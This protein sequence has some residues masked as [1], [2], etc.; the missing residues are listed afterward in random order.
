MKIAILGSATS[1]YAKDLQRAAASITA[2]GTR[3]EVTVLPFSR[4]ATTVETTECRVTSVDVQLADFDVTLVRSMP[5]GSLEQVVFRMN[6]L[7]SHE[8]AGY[9]VL[10]SARS[11]E[12]AID[13]Y[14]C[15]TKLRDA[16][17][18]TPA[19]FVCQTVEEAMEG[20]HAFGGDVVVKP[21]F[22]GEGRG[23]ARLNDP[24]IAS[25]A[26][27]L[28]AQNGAVL[29]LQQYIQHDGSDYRLLATGP[30]VFGIERSNKADWR[31][32]MSLGGTASRLDVTPELEE[33]T[34]RAMAATGVQIGALDLLPARDGTVYALEVNAVPGWRATARCLDV[35]VSR[36]VLEFLRDS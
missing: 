6:A 16:G 11:L 10:N 36:S 29:Y 27:K 23:I 9:T 30:R 33:M 31:T 24:A 28:L 3:I 15:L 13:K 18:A 26:F 22:G 7:A 20:F 34:L 17:F 25:H 21:I 4:L 8:A 19:T 12:I 1:W 2:S 32:N 5:L 35:D 14:H